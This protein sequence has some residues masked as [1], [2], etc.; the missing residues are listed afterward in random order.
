M[1]LQDHTQHFV[2]SSQFSSMHLF[3]Q[4]TTPLLHHSIH[5]FSRYVFCQEISWLFLKLFL[6]F[7]H[8][9]KNF[10][11]TQIAT[12][13]FHLKSITLTWVEVQN[14]R[15]T[16][17]HWLIINNNKIYFNMGLPF[18]NQSNK[19]LQPTDWEAGL[20]ILICSSS[21]GTQINYMV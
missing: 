17:K 7:F 6:K 5:T 13:I 19:G 16:N 9:R 11:A 8:F 1:G 14:L 20:W 2:S 4:I 15:R 12:K 21:S 3:I 10:S 18:T